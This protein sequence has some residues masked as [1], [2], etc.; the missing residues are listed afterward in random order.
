MILTPLHALSVSDEEQAQDSSS[1][2]SVS[3]SVLEAMAEVIAVRGLTRTLLSAWTQH[4]RSSSLAALT[5]HPELL[6]LTLF[7]HHSVI[8]WFGDTTQPSSQSQHQNIPIGCILLSQTIS[9]VSR[10]FESVQPTTSAPAPHNSSHSTTEPQPWQTP[11]L[12]TSLVLALA[13]LSTTGP[14]MEVG[15]FCSLFVCFCEVFATKHHDLYL[16]LIFAVGSE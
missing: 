15:C 14:V 8:D 13:V 7:E 5:A 16:T 4:S 11:E 2:A 3:W 6:P 1:F 9:A 12:T 10:V